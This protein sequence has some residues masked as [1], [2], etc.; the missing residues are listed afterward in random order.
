MGSL[1]WST[2]IVDFVEQNTFSHISS[3]PPCISVYQ[4]VENSEEPSKRQPTYLNEDSLN[5]N[6]N[7]YTMG[8]PA[9]VHLSRKGKLAFWKSSFS[10]SICTS[11]LAD[12]VFVLS[13]PGLDVPNVSSIFQESLYASISPL[14]RKNRD[15][16]RSH[17]FG[18]YTSFLRLQHKEEL[19]LKKWQE[20]YEAWSFSFETLPSQALAS[21]R[22]LPR[23]TARQKIR[24]ENKWKIQKKK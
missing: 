22:W 8:Q 1:N 4:L 20:W 14:K 6:I 19:W 18:A 11:H 12:S 16:S 2:Q 17:Y 10:N 24:K 5:A 23:I 9:E 13:K 21:A 15:S 7:P 3:Y